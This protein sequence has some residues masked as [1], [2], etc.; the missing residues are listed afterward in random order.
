MVTSTAT[1]QNACT[2]RASSHSPT[3]YTLINDNYG[4]SLDALDSVENFREQ[5]FAVADI[6]SN[7]S[8]VYNLPVCVLNSLA[9]IPECTYVW[10]QTTDG[11]PI[12][13]DQSSYCYIHPNNC[14]DGKWHSLQT[15]KSLLSSR[16]S[17]RLNLTSNKQIN[18]VSY[19]PKMRHTAFSILEIMSL[20]G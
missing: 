10:S 12:G 1:R 2:G 5:L 20:I 18:P 6:R 3:S 11:H 4:F 15:K 16:G 8:G 13:Y 9:S 19:L 14:L 7:N 17:L